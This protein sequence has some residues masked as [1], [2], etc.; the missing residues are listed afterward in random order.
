MVPEAVPTFH[1]S[2]T[3]AAASEAV[4]DAWVTPG[5]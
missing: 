5:S 2:Q 1:I 3:P 4:F